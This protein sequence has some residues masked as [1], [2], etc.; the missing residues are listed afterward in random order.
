MSERVGQIAGLQASSEFQAVLDMH[1]K[2]KE[3]KDV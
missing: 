3:D 1:N 2:V